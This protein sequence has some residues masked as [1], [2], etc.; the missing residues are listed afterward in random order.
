MTPYKYIHDLDK[1]KQI[2]QL[3][4]QEDKYRRLIKIN[5]FLILSLVIFNITGIGIHTLS[6]EDTK[7]ASPA[8]VQGVET[9]NKTSTIDVRNGLK[10]FPTEA[11]QNTSNVTPTAI[12]TPTLTKDT[13]TIAIIGDSM[14]DT[15]GE[16]LEYLEH[17]LKQKYPK[18]SFNLYNYGVGSENVEMGLARLGKD[19]KYKDREYPPL[20]TLHP[21]ILIIGSYAYNPFSPFDRDRHWLKLAELIQE[22]RKISP[23]VYLLAEIAPRK[24][25]FGKGPQG[26]RWEDDVR[27]A[28]AQ[29]IITQ[30]ENAFGLSRSLSIPLIDAYTPSIDPE[31]G[32][33]KK[34]FVNES[35]GI[36]P[37]AI[38][39]VYTAEK[40]VE[41]IQIE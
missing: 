38:G 31:T 20:N 11:V 41:T 24:R 14:V 7:I 16:R 4:Q 39:H 34:E 25:D 13:Y 1:T 19:F 10:P 27:D 17:V 29:K 30:M 12:P 28:H 33:V 23:K 2:V 9:E 21:D 22:G 35:D 37:S 8:S 3:I 40:I 18:T 6:N 15:M 32:E 5:I 36:H 26:L